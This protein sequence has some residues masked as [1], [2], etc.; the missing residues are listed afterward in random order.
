VKALPPLSTAAQKLVVGHDTDTRL[1][2]APTATGA[3]QDDPL[4]V[5]AFPA[6]V[7]AETPSTATQYVADAH[8][9]DSRELP[10]S[11]LVALDQVPL[12]V[13]EERDEDEVEVVAPPELLGTLVPLL[14]ALINAPASR[15]AMTPAASLVRRV[16][17]C[18]RW[19]L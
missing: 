19:A 6:V 9:T 4:Y 16:A 15:Q 18:K 10:I 12:A 7:P 8:D 5:S 11:R 2:T 14:H 3:D 17:T 1:P 13:D